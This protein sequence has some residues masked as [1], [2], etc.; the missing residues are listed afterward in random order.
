MRQT[1]KERVE[2][3]SL[4]GRASVSQ[5]FCVPPA[6]LVDELVMLKETVLSFKCSSRCTA[7]LIQLAAQFFMAVPIV[8]F[9]LTRAANP[10]GSK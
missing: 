7:W 4:P 9:D 1:Q 3:M 10:G 8:T 2:F 6:G 5:C